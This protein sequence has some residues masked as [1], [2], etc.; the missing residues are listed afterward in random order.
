L[1]Q[2]PPPTTHLVRGLLV[3]LLAGVHLVAFASFWF[4]AQGLIGPHGI[5]PIADFLDAVRAQ[6]GGEAYARVPTLFWL[7]SGGAALHLVCAAGVVVSVLAIA[8]FA[9]L[10]CFVVLWAL[11]L[12]IVQAGQDFMSFQWDVLLLE[13]GIVAWF[14]APARLRAGITDRTP[15]PAVGIWLMRLLVWKLMF[16]SGATKLLAYDDTWWQLTALDYHYYTQPLPWW[17]SWYMHQ[18]PSWFGKVSVA[19]TLVIEIGAPWLVFCGRGARLIGCA[20]LIALQLAIAWTG[21]YG[22]FNLLT[23]VLCVSLLDDRAIERML[24]TLTKRRLASA[25][26]RQIGEIMRGGNR[27]AIVRGVLALALVAASLL[28]TIRELDRTLAPDHRTGRVAR[29]LEWSGTKLLRPARP[30]L[31]AIAPYH[32]VNGYG[33]FRSM[34]TTR[35]EIVIEASADGA[36]WSEIEFPWKPGDLDRRPRLVAPHQPR[37]DWQMWFAA[38]DPRHTGWLAP[39]MRRLLEGEP[40]VYQLLDAPQWKAKAPRYVRL[41]YYRYEFTDAEARRSTGAWWRREPIG[42]LTERLSLEDLDRSRR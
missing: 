33:L 20:L 16:L 41:R 28:V 38:L 23:I 34:T 1:S 36:T 27:A 4:Q 37:L 32:S 3:R 22:F 19:L 17:T 12:S 15:P 21:N 24:P 30:A 39:L 25:T 26:A 10:L 6:I 7:S 35:P 42:A 31:A 9:P 8:G 40:E 5:L 18:L 11:Y 14:L 2:Q 13:A 29:A